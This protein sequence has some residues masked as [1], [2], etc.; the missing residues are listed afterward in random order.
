MCLHMLSTRMQGCHVDD[1]GRTN[2]Q[3][4]G[5]TMA[6]GSSMTWTHCSVRYEVTWGS[7]SRI[8]V[9]AP[10][11]PRGRK[12]IRADG[13]RSRHGCQGIWRDYIR[14]PQTFHSHF[15]HCL[16]LEKLQCV[17]C[18]LWSRLR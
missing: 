4:D 6:I 2:K 13:Q 10:M 16:G 7:N 18:T 5:R 12:C 11:G 3:T 9:D 14:G 17:W 15:L 1:S 8:R